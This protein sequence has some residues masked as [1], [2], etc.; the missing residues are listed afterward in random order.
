MPDSISQPVMAFYI[1]VVSMLTLGITAWFTPATRGW[2]LQRF[3]KK[4]VNSDV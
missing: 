3:Y 1:E 4:E 2:V